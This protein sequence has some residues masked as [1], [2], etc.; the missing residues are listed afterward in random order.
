VLKEFG[1]RGV[2]PDPRHP[3]DRVALR[4]WREALSRLE[5]RLAEKGIVEARTGADRPPEAA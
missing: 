4:L 1:D 3:G 5:W 2:A